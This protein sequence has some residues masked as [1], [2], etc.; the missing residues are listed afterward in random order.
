M[1]GIERFSGTL[2][3]FI[4]RSVG[5]PVAV[6]LEGAGL[7]MVTVIAVALNSGLRNLP[8]DDKIED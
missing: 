5:V 7:M 3:A 4:A 1:W 6:A 2:V 8:I